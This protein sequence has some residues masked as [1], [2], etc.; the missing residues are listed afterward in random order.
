MKL[1]TGSSAL[2]RYEP[3]LPSYDAYL[4]ARHYQSQLTPESMKRA[5]ESFEQAIA[6]DPGFALPHAELGGYFVDLATFGLLPAH[7]SMPRARASAQ[8]AL[9]C[10]PSLPEAQTVLG[11]VAGA[12]DH[13]WKDAE[14]RFQL[15]LARE[16]V[17]PVVHQY[18]GL[19]HLYFVGR[20]LD[21]A[22]EIALALESDPLNSYWRQALAF[23]HMAAGKDAEAIAE[24]H[25]LL[26][27]DEDFHLAYSHLAV[28]ETSRG[29]MTEA[30]SFIE[31]AY[32]LAPWLTG[33]IGLL[34]GLLLRTG[35]DA[36]RA[37]ATLHNLGD[38]SAYGSPMG[39]FVFH[40]VCGESDKAADW[41]EAGIVQRDPAIIYFLQ[42]PLARGLRSSTRWPGLTRSLSLPETAVQVV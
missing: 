25:R 33:N 18:Y 13:D 5:S 3:K 26:E 41:A 16:P 39:F 28:I 21:A 19:Y 11:I 34:A 10:D 6:L 31:K 24:L 40:L 17:P 20:P 36:S 12:Y 8:R 22:R 42:G 1:A 38:G 2:R 30:L 27:F 35:G 15:A 14:R 4:K 29:V 32:E 9:E 7:E 37:A 23:C